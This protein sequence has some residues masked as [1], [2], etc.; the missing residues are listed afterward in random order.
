MALTRARVITGDA[1]FKQRIKAVITAAL[2]RPRDSQSLRADVVTM[3]SRMR[4][5]R[6][7]RDCWDIKET[8][9]GLTDMGFLAQYLQLRF[10]AT[11]PDI[12]AHN[13]S[14]A[15]MRLAKAGLLPEDTAKILIDATYMGRRIASASR[16]LF[17]RIGT[18]QLDKPACWPI[19]ARAVTG[20]DD[21][22][23]ASEITTRLKN[24][25]AQAAQ[26]YQSYLGE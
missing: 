15:F 10:A 26:I 6:P 24:N 25:L 9:G 4:Q 2:C 22:L 18:P 14:Q 13:S 1:D 23:D 11:H 12:L 3:R 19:L 8:A 5:Q 17:G 7:P 21:A 16:L 20:H